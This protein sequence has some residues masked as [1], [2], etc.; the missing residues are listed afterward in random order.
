M[1]GAS[2]REGFRSIMSYGG[3][4]GR[5]PPRFSMGDKIRKSERGRGRASE[6][7]RDER[8]ESVAQNDREICTGDVY[9]S[10]DPSD[11]SRT[12]KFCRERIIR[13]PAADTN[14][15][16][17]T[18]SSAIR[19]MRRRRNYCSLLCERGSLSEWRHSTFRSIALTRESGTT[20]R[21]TLIF[22]PFRRYDDNAEEIYDLQ[23]RWP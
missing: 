7:Q 14:H 10:A 20:D 9:T 5:N 23:M 21:G 13:R 1:M 16:A 19:E 2:N 6:R 17:A 3:Y 12:G 4:S 18:I 15:A 22:A 11:K 8:R